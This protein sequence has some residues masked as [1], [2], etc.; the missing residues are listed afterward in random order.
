MLGTIERVGNKVP[1]PAI[2][3]LALCVIVIALS[4]I[5][6]LADVGVTYEVATPPVVEVEQDHLG[7]SGNPYEE[8]PPPDATIPDY[9]IETRTQGIESLLSADGIRFLVTSS[10][11]NVNNFGVIA[12]ILVAMIGVGVAEESGLIA[13]LIR[14]MVRVAPPRAITAIIVFIGMLSSV[15]TDAGY[16]VLIPLGAAAF[17]TLGRNPLAGIAVAFAGVSA[18]FGV[19]LLIA[20]VDGILTE[21]TNESISLVDPSSTIDVTANLFFAIV[22]TFFVT[23][24]LTVVSERIVEPSIGPYDPSLGGEGSEGVPELTA[25]EKVAEKK[26]LRYA[27]FALLGALL[28]VVL[29]T[30]PPGAPLRNPE[31]GAVFGDSPLMSG[32]I[33]VI[34]LL[35]LAAGLGFGRGSGRLSGSV[36]VI[37][38]ITKTF[39]GL[40]GLIFL[41]VIVAQFIAYFNYSNMPTVAAV[42]LAETLESANISTVWLLLGFILVVTALNLIMPGVIP[43]W[44]ILAP[45]FIPLFMQLGV[46]P[47]TVLAAYRVGDG[48]TNVITPLMVYL[49]FIVLLMQRYRKDAGVGTVVSLMLPFTAVLAVLW[50][51]FFVAWFLLGVPLGPGAPV[52]M[53]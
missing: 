12:V 52:D 34:S 2:I 39:A 9:E 11:Q 36:P 32:L 21:I 6:Y 46:A 49:P 42:S 18:G 27:G 19:N 41:L 35:F 47:Q 10:V 45:I 22:S 20:P 29:L 53:T 17:L 7:G 26:G 30:A 28:V 51:L 37:G 25:E 31:T 38:A 50:T 16:L 8:V 15:A 4:H 33:L 5:L 48:P 40:G 44:A 3:F 43:K 24:V 13:A 14:S 23:A 1:H